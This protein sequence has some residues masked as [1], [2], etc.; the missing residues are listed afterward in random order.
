MKIEV[1]YANSSRHAV[2]QVDVAEG[3]TLE[4]AITQSGILARFPE[5]DLTS[6]KVGIFGRVKPLATAVAAGD[7]IEIYRPVTAKA[8]EVLPRGEKDDA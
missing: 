2:V 5:I 7:R 8:S 4:A 1:A 3:T 6:Q